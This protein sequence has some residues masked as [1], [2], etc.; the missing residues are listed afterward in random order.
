MAIAG[1]MLLTGCA[2]AKQSPP[3][4][5]TQ[6]QTTAQETAIL[7]QPVSPA[8]P[9]YPYPPE[10]NTSDLAAA[11]L[12]YPTPAPTAG[13]LVLTVISPYPGAEGAQVNVTEQPGGASLVATSPYPVS[14]E[15]NPADAAAEATP[16]RIIKKEL[17]AS[18][19]NQ[20]QLASGK[21]QLIEFFAFWDG[22]SKALAPTIHGLEADYGDRLNFIYLDIDNPANDQFKKQLGYK[23]QPEFFLLDQRGNIIQQ[24]SS[25]VTKN[26]L[27]A[28]IE[29]ILP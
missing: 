19:P 20:V 14:G 5:A 24:W 7:T 17:L 21:I 11:Q 4:S 2:D 22:L 3:T 23:M 10:L 8:A 27:R 28:T 25:T 1:A 29:A 18:D 13:E 26:E 15:A 16:T 6:A 9:T 12:A